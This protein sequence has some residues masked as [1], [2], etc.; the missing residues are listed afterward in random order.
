LN[1]LNTNTTIL[2]IE[3]T[4]ELCSVSL[5]FSEKEIFT[6]GIQKK[7]VHSEKLL[8]LVDS[9]FKT[10]STEIK[11]I[12]AIAVSMGPGSFTGL[13]IGLSAAKGLAT[14][15]ELPIIPV[16]TFDAMALEA[17][18]ILP[19]ES[20]F[21]IANSVNITELYVAR[22]TIHDSAIKVATPLNLILKKEFENYKNNDD[23]ILGN[24]APKVFKKFSEPGAEFICRWAYIYGKDLLTFDYDYLEPLYLKDFVA[25]ES[26]K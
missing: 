23:I 10:A 1:E 20:Q 14:G 18:T 13:R 4:G 12:G 3:T 16:P 22:Y 25:K 2:G 7:H 5:F 21:I 17:A 24:F 9:V 19:D 15:A 26:K 11:N 8:E 6:S